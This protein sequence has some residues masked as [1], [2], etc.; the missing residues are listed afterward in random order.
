VIER[1][2]VPML[3]LYRVE[4]S[5]MG[6]L[7]YTALLYADDAEAAAGRASWAAFKDASVFDLTVNIAVVPDEPKVP[8][9]ENDL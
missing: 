8:K 2:D 1:M 4:L 9:Y 5:R 7:V 3:T 6:Q